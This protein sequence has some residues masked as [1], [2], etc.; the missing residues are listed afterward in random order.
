MKAWNATASKASQ[1]VG[2]KAMAVRNL[3]DLTPPDQSLAVPCLG[4]GSG[5]AW[6]WHWQ[7]VLAWACHDAAL[8]S[9]EMHL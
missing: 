4:I 2:V 8:R 5:K 3:L 6:Q 7:C 9:V 1:L